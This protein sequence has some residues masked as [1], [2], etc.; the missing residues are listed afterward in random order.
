MP[1]KDS[2]DEISREEKWTTYCNLSGLRKKEPPIKA[3]ISFC[4][5]SKFQVIAERIL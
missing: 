5:G 1:E 2:V 4:C 3:A